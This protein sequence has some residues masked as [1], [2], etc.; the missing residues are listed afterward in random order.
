[1]PGETKT[2]RWSERDHG[3]EA[4]AREVLHEFIVRRCGLEFI[5]FGGRPYPVDAHRVHLGVGDVVD[6]GLPRTLRM[7]WGCRLGIWRLGRMD[8]S[9]GAYGGQGLGQGG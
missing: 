5:Q 9:R 3:V 2:L 6:H 7:V 1:M 4:L 8:A